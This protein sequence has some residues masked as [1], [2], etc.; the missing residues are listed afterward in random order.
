[1][2]RT[3]PTTAIAIALRVRTKV[4]T[5]TL[6]TTM[7]KN[8]KGDKHAVPKTTQSVA[9]FMPILFVKQ[10]DAIKVLTNSFQHALGWNEPHIKSNKL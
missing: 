5:R 6:A 4:E 7:N 2:I 1:M 3:T 8:I 9:D 10:T